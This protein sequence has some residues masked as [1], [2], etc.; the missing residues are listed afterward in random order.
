MQK[1]FLLLVLLLTTPAF[2]G[3]PEILINSLLAERMK[4]K[5]G[6][7]VE[8]ALTGDMKRAETFRVRAIYNE[9]A[10]PYNVPL[11][12]NIVKMHLPDLE[13]LSGR[14]DQV[15]LISIRL[16]NPGEAKQIA[17]RLNT[18]A[19]GFSA[20]S[21]NEL[22]RKSSTT[23]EVVNRFHEAIALITMMA[24]AIFI[25]ALVV[26]RV[27]DQRKNLAILTVTGISRG[28]ILK[29]LVLESMFFAFF[30][31]LLGA[32]LGYISAAAVNIYY[33]HYYKTTLLFAQVTPAILLRAILLSFLLGLIAGS[34]SWLRLRRLAILEEL[35]R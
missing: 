29:T 15:D 8:I 33:Q 2:S 31:S 30:A 22:A 23:F 35:G 14:S 12:R 7:V 11:K 26:M 17:A 32:V 5:P 25:F 19:I 27:E 13:R 9:K 4:L 20:Y 1:I 16:R 18:E 34:F 24:G 6:D 3:T 21:A 10:D 28:T